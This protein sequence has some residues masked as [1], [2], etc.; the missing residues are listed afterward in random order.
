MARSMTLHAIMHWKNGVDVS[1]WPHAVTYATHVYN[2]TPKDGVCP[3]YIFFGSAV[4]RLID[5]HV[6]GCPVEVL[7]QKIQQG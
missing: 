7:D 2:T 1:L 3:A 4:P 6:W 5:L